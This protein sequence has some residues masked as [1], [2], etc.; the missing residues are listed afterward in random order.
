MYGKLA[1]VEEVVEGEMKR[2]EWVLVGSEV[3]E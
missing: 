1:F 3:L 2:E